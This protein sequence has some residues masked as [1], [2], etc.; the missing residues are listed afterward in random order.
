MTSDANDADPIEPDLSAR[1]SD[2]EA[3]LGAVEQALSALSAARFAP[4]GTPPVSAQPPP[5]PPGATPVDV[6]PPSDRRYPVSPPI[7]TSGPTPAGRVALPAINT[8]MAL[9]W[10]GVVLVFLAAVFL[11]STAISRGWIGPEVQLGLATIGGAALVATGLHLDRR[12]GGDRR[13]WSLALTNTGV[14]VL[15]VC[16]GAAHGW[17][18]LVG[19]RTAVAF[20]AIVLVLALALADWFRHESLAI[21]GLAVALVVPGFIGAYDDFGDAGTG[22]WLLLLVV[23]AMALAGR[24]RWWLPRLL[25]LVVI[26]PFMVL[27]TQEFVDVTDSLLPVIQLMIATAG[28]LWWLAPWLRPADV[29]VR[30][31]DHRLVFI[32]PGLVWLSSAGLWADTDHERALVALLVAAGFAVVTAAIRFLRSGTGAVEAP[33][34]EL[35]FSHLVGVSSLVTVALALWFDGPALLAALTLQALGTVV[36][37]L[38]ADDRFLELNAALLLGAAGV[39]TAEGLREGIEVGLDV[40]EAAVYLLAI[41]VAAATAW[42]V[43]HRDQT[44]AGVVAVSGWVGLLA[45]VMAVLRP[46][47]QGQMLVSIVWA[48]LG[49]ALVVLGL[50]ALNLDLPGWPDAVHRWRHQVKSLGLATLAATVVKLVTIDL[51]EVDTIWRA[52]LFAVVGV[53]LLRLGYRIGLLERSDGADPADDRNGAADG[54]S[55]G[56]GLS[57][58]S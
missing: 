34:N 19:I 31:L 48:V 37:A 44:A 3:R 5:P 27:L 29:P 42:L 16:A 54:E 36:I 10:A 25:S 32:V 4:P 13:P 57:P 53:G 47:P 15:G 45:W 43:R 22:A 18:D 2:L 8:E 12:W 7:A 58:P 28:L 56:G 14:V 1:L 20:V 9:R 6:A 11:L 38:R 41:V 17:L 26:G 40:P 51:A 35:L 50:G 23:V 39:W 33:S 24:Y 52:L 46:L 21:G 49:V 30:P 55:S